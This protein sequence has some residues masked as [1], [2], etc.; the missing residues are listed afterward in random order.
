M[1]QLLFMD[2]LSKWPLKNLGPIE[3]LGRVLKQR[4]KWIKI[5]SITKQQ[6]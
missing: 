5:S 3:A 2:F 1:G 4:I 6:T